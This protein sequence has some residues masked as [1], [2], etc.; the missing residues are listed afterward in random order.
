MIT[1]KQGTFGEYTVKMDVPD[2]TAIRKLAKAYAIPFD[3][4][5][6]ACINKGVDVIGDKV[7]D[8]DGQPQGRDGSGDFR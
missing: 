7:K 4:M 6:V 8:V 5:L 1:A 2:V 3:A